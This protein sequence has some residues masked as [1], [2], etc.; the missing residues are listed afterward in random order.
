M[1]K[2]MRISLAAF[3]F[4]FAAFSSAFMDIANFKPH[5][6]EA[7]DWCAHDWRA[8]YVEGDPELGRV[9]WFKIGKLKIN[10]PV[11]IIDG[12][13]FFKMLQVIALAFALIIALDLRRWWILLALASSY[14]LWNGT[15][16]LF[17]KYIL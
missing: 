6:F 11:Q 16:M 3:L 2:A 9:V 7:C 10:K 14:I 13:H 5:R 8:K 4:A 1:S 15:F 12:W 17:Y